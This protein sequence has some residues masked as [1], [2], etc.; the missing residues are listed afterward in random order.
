[1]AVIEHFDGRPY[2]NK[3]HYTKICDYELKL[4]GSRFILNSDRTLLK[5]ISELDIREFKFSPNSYSGL[6][7]DKFKEIL[8]ECC[9][10]ED[11]FTRL[12][13]F[14][15]GGLKPKVIEVFKKP[16]YQKN[17]FSSK[18]RILN[19]K[20]ELPHDQLGS[21]ASNE[22]YE[23][24]EELI[25]GS[26]KQ[27]TTSDF[28]VIFSRNKLN[29][30]PTLKIKGRT[31]SSRIKQYFGRGHYEY[32]TFTSNEFY[33]E[34][35]LTGNIIISCRENPYIPDPYYEKSRY[36][37]EVLV[38]LLRQCLDFDLE[39]QIPSLDLVKLNNL[40]RNFLTKLKK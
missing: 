1:M 8:Y 2:T 12:L 32:K 31:D 25:G 30:V 18:V 22:V 17:Y 3:L 13:L 15:S 9:T 28:N 24:A 26:L 34:A 20:Y 10:V 11:R 21:F 19:N 4:D 23:L 27:V 6:N 40:Y 33:P 16:T 35:I 7:S 14:E 29:K 36:S 39:L 5:R 38:D 37:H